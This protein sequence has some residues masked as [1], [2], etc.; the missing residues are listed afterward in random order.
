MKKKVFS[1][2]TVICVSPV[3]KLVV[4]QFEWYYC[5]WRKKHFEAVEND[6]VFPIVVVFAFARELCWENFDRQTTR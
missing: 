3:L 5:A 2:L 4:W 6:N 1:M